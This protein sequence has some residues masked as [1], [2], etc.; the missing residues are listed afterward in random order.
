MILFLDLGT[1]VSPRPQLVL[2]IVTLAQVL[3]ESQ[4]R[5]RQR[6]SEGQFQKPTADGAVDPSPGQGAGSQPLVSGAPGPR[7]SGCP[8]WQGLGSP[9]LKA[10]GQTQG[11]PSGAR[12]LCW[13]KARVG[14]TA[15]WGAWLCRHA[16]TRADTRLQ[17]HTRLF[18]SLCVLLNAQSDCVHGSRV[19]FPITDVHKGLPGWERVRERPTTCQEGPG[20]VCS[21]A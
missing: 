17:E 7:T 21:C 8:P 6:P 9:L 2:R 10:R 19:H 5:A 3:L 20:C 11:T 14:D 12:H 15:E 16:Q 1:G 13:G 4:Q 18:T